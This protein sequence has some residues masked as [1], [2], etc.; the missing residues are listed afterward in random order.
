MQ[1]ITIVLNFTIC[2]DLIP[3]TPPTP[4]PPS[5]LFELPLQMFG[6]MMVT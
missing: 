2:E 4:L 6:H 3:P 1:F 5:A